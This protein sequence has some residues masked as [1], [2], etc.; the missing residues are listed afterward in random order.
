MRSASEPARIA[1][2]CTGLSLVAILALSWPLLTGRVLAGHDMAPLLFHGYEMAANIADGV[3]LPAW[4]ASLNTGFGGPT[5]LFYPPFLNYVHG[6]FALGGFRLAETVG[7]VA[8]AL[9]FLSGLSAFAF[10]RSMGLRLGAV[11]GALAYIVMPYRLIVLYDRTALPEHAAFLWPPLIMMVFERIASKQLRSLPGTVLAS[12][13]LS[14][15][16]LTNTPST[17]F[18]GGLIAAYALYRGLYRELAG[19]A[20][21]AGLTSAFLLVPQALSSR[22]LYSQTLLFGQAGAFRP[23]ANTLFSASSLIPP[24]TQR[25]SFVVTGVTLLG[26]TCLLLI[27]AEKERRQVFLFW[28]AAAL[29]A[30]LLTLPPVGPVWDFLPVISKL[31]FP[32]RLGAPLTIC[33]AVLL[34]GVAETRFRIASGLLGAAFVVSLFLSG[35]GTMP[36]TL[37][38]LPADPLRGPISEPLLTDGF[39]AEGFYRGRTDIWFLPRDVKPPVLAELTGQTVPALATLRRNH[40]A[41]TV[42]GGS[43][44]LVS[45]RRLEQQY[46]V[47]LPRDG[48]MVFG[49]LAFPGMEVTASGRTLQ[50]FSEPSTGFLAAQLPAGSHSITWRWR[51]FEPLVTAR[52]VSLMTACLVALFLAFEALTRNTNA[53]SG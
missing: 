45:W 32:W 50:T 5:L 31:Q 47:S 29:S 1:I 28:G 15:L 39:T 25:V 6:L 7:F 42:P 2:L 12:L 35:T 37:L 34:A 17:I 44:K 4:G 26:L 18:S 53:L 46:L 24:F 41:L 13:L 23:S 49:V 52:W 40:A 22:F 9:W 14:A 10:L 8:I 30:F 43:L 36:R 38:T 19:S 27:L 48:A 21:I 51:P 16:L 3:W 11:M 33:T 20:V